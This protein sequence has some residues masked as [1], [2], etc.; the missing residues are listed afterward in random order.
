M[1]HPK[2]GPGR[3]EGATGAVLDMGQ[4]QSGDRRPLTKT[5]DWRFLL[6]LLRCQRPDWKYYATFMDAATAARFFLAEDRNGGFHHPLTAEPIDVRPKWSLKERIRARRVSDRFFGRYGLRAS[7]HADAG[8]DE[9]VQV[10]RMTVRRSGRTR[11]LRH[12]LFSLTRRYPLGG[13][14]DDLI[15]SREGHLDRVA[16][17]L[18]AATAR[19]RNDRNFCPLDGVVKPIEIHERSPDWTWREVCG[20]QWTYEVCPHCLFSFRSSLSLM[21]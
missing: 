21:N 13:R 9:T 7:L 11:W 2:D 10:G 4:L 17:V 20:R 3:P 15:E 6:A 5:A 14:L 1:S 18:A 19:E 12:L 8:F 16:P